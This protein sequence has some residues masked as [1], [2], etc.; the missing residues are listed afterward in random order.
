MISKNIPGVH[1]TVSAMRQ[2]TNQ[3][4]VFVFSLAQTEVYCNNKKH[5]MGFSDLLMIQNSGEK[6]IMLSSNQE[7][8]TGWWN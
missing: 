5:K 1:V 3:K 7:I 8:I 4:F 6:E 2:T